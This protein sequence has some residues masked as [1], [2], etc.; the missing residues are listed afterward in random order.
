MRNWMTK[1]SPNETFDFQMVNQFCPVDREHYDREVP[2]SP[3]DNLSLRCTTC[4]AA[5]VEEKIMGVRTDFESTDG[6]FEW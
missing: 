1:E 4:T 5:L 6:S 3:N 2:E